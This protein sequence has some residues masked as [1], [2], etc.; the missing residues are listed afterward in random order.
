M[1]SLVAIVICI[2][3]PA[4]ALQV[5]IFK[6]TTI[7]F[8]R[9]RLAWKT[10]I[11]VSLIIIPFSICSAILSRLASGKPLLGVLQLLCIL[12]LFLIP[13][14]LI[15]NSLRIKTLVSIGIVVVS[16]IVS[17]IASIG[18]AY[19]IRSYLVQAFRISSAGMAPTLSVGDYMFVN[20][21]IYRFSQP[22]RNDIIAFQYQGSTSKDIVQRIVAIGG[23]MVEIRDKKVLINGKPYEKDPG[24]NTSQEVLPASK[25]PRDNLPSITVPANSFFVL[26]DNRDSSFDS[27]FWGF[28]KYEHIVGKPFVIYWS[29]DTVGKHARTERIGKWME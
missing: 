22:R 18:Y 9:H 19:A 3:V 5:L 1:T 14:I 23:D 24:T 28:V 25:S 8:G 17:S 11:I 13:I 27:R 21:F 10:A 15:R 29:Y 6:G 16:V 4:F 20:K 12:G 2:L 7:V 26:G